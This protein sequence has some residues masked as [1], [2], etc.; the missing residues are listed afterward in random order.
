MI[1]EDGEAH[2]T[3]EYCKEV[4]RAD[5]DALKEIRASLN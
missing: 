5:G 1:E 3:C 2:V 4:Y